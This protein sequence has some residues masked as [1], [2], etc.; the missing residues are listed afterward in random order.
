MF[1]TAAGA[2]V[3]SPRSPAQVPGSRTATFAAVPTIPQKEIRNNVSAVLRRAEAGEE[4]T[5]T[6]SGRPV[7]KLGPLDKAEPSSDEPSPWIDS[8]AAA[9]VVGLPAMP[10]WMEDIELGFGGDL[11]NPWEPGD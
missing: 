10:E 7:A 8:A 4:F 5:I 9:E 2:P 3:A 1:V 6:V 11:R